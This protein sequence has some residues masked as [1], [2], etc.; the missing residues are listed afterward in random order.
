VA[1]TPMKRYRNILKATVRDESR[2]RKTSREIAIV[3]IK[4]Y[5]RVVSAVSKPLILAQVIQDI[6]DVSHTKPASVDPRQGELFEEYRVIE[7]I[8]FPIIKDGKRVRTER[9]D[10]GDLTYNEFTQWIEYR[11]ARPAKKSEPLDGYIRL[12]DEIRPYATGKTKIEAAYRAMK[13][14]QGSGGP[15]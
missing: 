10:L 12:H 6:N 15:E 11:Q 8:A 4:R 1:L 9:R 5:G 2:S 14:A 13:K 7:V 3:F